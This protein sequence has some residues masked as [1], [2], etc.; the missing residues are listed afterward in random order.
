MVDATGPL[1]SAETVAANPEQ[2]RTADPDYRLLEVNVQQG[3]DESSHIPEMADRRR[4]AQS[5]QPR[6]R[7]FGL[8][9]S[10]AEP[11]DEQ[12][13]PKS[14]DEK[15]PQAR[16]R[17]GDGERADCDVVDGHFVVPCGWLE[18]QRNRDDLTAFDGDRLSRDRLAAGR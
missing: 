8:I 1:V 9:P 16:S 13:A 6:R 10:A 17:T 2:I 11:Q 12:H 5:L 18:R 14:T 4:Q 7:R 3:T 15:P